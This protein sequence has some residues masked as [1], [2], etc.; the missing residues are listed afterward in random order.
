MKYICGDCVFNQVLRSK[1]LENI[2]TGDCTYCGAINTKITESKAL[3]EFASDRLLNSLYSIEDAT[4]YES[5]MFWEGTDEIPFNEI[6]Y[7]IQDLKV[8]H[9]EFEDEVADYVLSN[10]NC[11][12]DLF[13]LDDG[14]HGN[15]TYQS[16]WTDFIKST[17]YQNRFFN[18]DAKVF[19]D[20]LFDLLV[21]EMDLKNEVLTE[22]DSSIQ[23]FRARI[24]NNEAVRKDIVSDPSSELG[25]VP[26]YLAG[27]QRMT[28]TG[29]SAFYCSLDR[30][31][32]FSEIRAVTGD[33]VISGAFSPTDKLV[34]L[35]LAKIQ[36]LRKLN[37]DP[38]EENYSDVYNKTV[39][40]KDLMFL[41]SKPASK[42]NSSSYL[43]TQIIFEYL[44]LKFGDKLS[45]LMFNSIQTGGEGKNIAFFPSYSSVKMSLLNSGNVESISEHYSNLFN[46]KSYFY[47]VNKR[48][49]K[50]NENSNNNFKLA[51]VEDSLLASKVKGVITKTEGIEILINQ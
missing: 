6:I 30:E 31:T 47:S 27:E 50:S 43:S 16:K 17:S 4:S 46:S 10:S 45:G 22:I 29:I 13:V 48:D 25:P 12:T 3:L 15:N 44:S 24:A 23:L 35:D 34:L 20:A 51:Y 32:C 11:K 39:F 14:F 49:V 5:A 7:I 19:L 26:V 18:E 1:L 2:I 37:L 42:N 33:L 9:E 21:D 8:G 41:M 36:N 40:I 38:F 28:P